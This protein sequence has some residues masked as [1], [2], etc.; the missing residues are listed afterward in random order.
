MC[1]VVV[2]TM[3]AM[4]CLHTYFF[5]VNFLKPLFIYTCENN[6]LIQSSTQIVAY[7]MLYWLVVTA[8][9]VTAV[10]KLHSI[11]AR[12]WLVTVCMCLI[13]TWTS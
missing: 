6:T 11:L 9:I 3:T 1:I 2:H 4:N 5:W 7:G 12:S 8:M 10:N 13:S